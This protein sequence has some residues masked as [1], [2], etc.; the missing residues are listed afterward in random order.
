MESA[1]VPPIDDFDWMIFAIYQVIGDTGISDECIYSFVK[2]EN[3][4]TIQY[5]VDYEKNIVIKIR[6]KYTKPN[7]CETEADVTS[8][9]LIPPRFKQ[10]YTKRLKQK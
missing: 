2:N 1:G 3:I 8:G 5:N 6:K 7:V 10:R 4:V 9:Y